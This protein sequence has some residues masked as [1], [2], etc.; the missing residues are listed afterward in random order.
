MAKLY[1]ISEACQDE[2]RK[3]DVVFIHGLGGDAFGTWRHGEGDDTSWPHWLAENSPDIGV[4]SL[5]HAADPSK[6][7]GLLAGLFG[8]GGRDAGQGMSLPDRAGQILDLMRL[9]RH[10]RGERPIVFVCHSLG[11]LLAKQILRQ[12]HDNAGNTGTESISRRT[13]GVLFLATPHNGA[14]L[15]TLA[16]KFAAICGPTASL[17]AL[18]AHDPHLRNLYNWYRN[19]A[20]RLGIE[21]E[22]YYEGHDVFGLRIV[23]ETSSQPGVGPDAVMLDEDHLSIAKPREPDAQV[24]QALEEMLRKVART[25]PSSAAGAKPSGA[26]RVVPQPREHNLQQNTQGHGTARRNTLN[27]GKDMSARSGGRQTSAPSWTY[28]AGALVVVAFLIWVIFFFRFSWPE[29]QPTQASV[30]ISDPPPAPLSVQRTQPPAAAL[31]VQRAEA[32]GGTAINASGNA[33]VSVGAVPALEA[34]KPVVTDTPPS[35]PAVHP[36]QDAKA[37]PGGRAIN[38]SGDAKVKVETS[39]QT[40]P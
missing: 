2:H 35:E 19:H 29:P 18:K 1:G 4:W 23:D 32:H 21:T 3:A 26:S 40:Q 10:F 27:Q 12:A 37:G 25:D 17:E 5:E 13:A 15:A 14:G 20:P 16:D 6:P 22:T 9:D 33:Q 11:G 8:K 34:A 7:L 31:P 38:A 30:Q 36:A 39:A 24:C 28:V